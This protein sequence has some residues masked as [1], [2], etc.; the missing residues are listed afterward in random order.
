[1]KERADKKLGLD[2]KKVLLGRPAVSLITEEH[3]LAV[4]R[5]EKAAKLAGLKK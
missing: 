1:M 3:D 4:D 2:V 5:L